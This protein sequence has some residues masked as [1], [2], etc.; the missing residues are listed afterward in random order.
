MVN[1]LG[2]DLNFSFAD[3]PGTAHRLTGGP[4]RGHGV[5]GLPVPGEG[6]LQLQLTANPGR[7]SEAELAG[8][9]SRF[10]EC[11]AFADSPDSEIADL[12]LLLPGERHQLLEEWNSTAAEVT[13]ATLPSLFESRVAAVPDNTAVVFSGEQLTYGEL[14]A[15]ANR[16][17]TV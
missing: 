12:P 4:H 7:Y 2:F 10:V 8:H 9:L 16:V 11:R 13:P 15:R 6:G 5:R 17:A 1:V 14:N 3:T